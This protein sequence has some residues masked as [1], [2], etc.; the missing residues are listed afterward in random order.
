MR[1]TKPMLA[2]K[3]SYL[4]VST[5]CFAFGIAHFFIH[6]LIATSFGTIIAVFLIVFGAVKLLGYFSKDLF[7]LSFQ[8]D[9][10]SGLL[11]V[12]VGLF[13]LFKPDDAAKYLP[14]ILGFLAMADGLL[15]IQISIDSKKFGIKLWWLIMAV[16][17]ICCLVGLAIVFRLSEFVHLMTLFV[18]ILLATEGLLN[19][20][21]VIFTVKIVKYQKPD[22]FQNKD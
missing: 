6:D 9:M 4:V 19:L 21:V 3:I 12:V 10:A 13:L 18:G 22:E 11:M 15:K 2:A 1:S 20:I 7:R 5:L 16:A 14:V 8:H 17:V